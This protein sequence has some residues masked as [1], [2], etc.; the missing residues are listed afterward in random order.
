MRCTA[1]YK[2][3]I[4]VIIISVV[5]IFGFSFLLED[6]NINDKVIG[7]ESGKADDDFLI[8]SLSSSL[9]SSSSFFVIVIGDFFSFYY[10][11]SAS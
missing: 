5:S 7:N 3:I 8:L 4:I 9:S 10:C 2:E 1:D 11:Y 6:N